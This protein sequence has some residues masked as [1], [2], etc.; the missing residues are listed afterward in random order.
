MLALFGQGRAVQI[1]SVAAWEE[2]VTAMQ[3]GGGAG[4]R[5]EK[6]A[7]RSTAP[8]AQGRPEVK[9]LTYGEQLE[10]REIEGKIAVAEAQLA[11]CE[12]RVND[13]S[14][15]KDHLALQAAC[16]AFETAQRTVDEL[17]AR[18]HELEERRAASA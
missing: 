14:I 2:V 7:P 4:A 1:P 5:S 9:R 3:R 11:A 18:W 8:A 13:P 17:L 12:Q 16:R 6:S 15:G 10:L